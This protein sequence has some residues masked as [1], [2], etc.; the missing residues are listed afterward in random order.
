M[1]RHPLVFSVV[2]VLLLATLVTVTTL[3]GFDWGWLGLD[4]PWLE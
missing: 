2:A 4:L 3:V 1:K